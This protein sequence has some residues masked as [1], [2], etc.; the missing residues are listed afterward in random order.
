MFSV[1]FDQV[2]WLSKLWI[3]FI[4]TKEGCVLVFFSKQSV[5]LREPAK[6]YLADFFRRGREGVSPNF[7]GN[8]V[9]HAVV[10]QHKDWSTP[11]SSNSKGIRPGNDNAR[12]ALLR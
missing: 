11:A 2:V 6:Y 4:D 5:T 3:W 9:I 8:R 10:K 12:A 7:E 1:D